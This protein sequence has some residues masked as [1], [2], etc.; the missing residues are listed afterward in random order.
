[1]K[2]SNHAEEIT[3]RF[4]ELIEDAGDSLV[5]SHYNELSLLIEAGIE[6]ALVDKLE[7]MADKL[8]KI[9][10]DIRHDAEFFDA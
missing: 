7:K 5:D 2:H 9:A 8:D 3:R 4:R 1:M 6:T 10:N